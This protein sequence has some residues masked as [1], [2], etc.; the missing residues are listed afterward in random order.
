[1]EIIPRLIGY[2]TLLLFVTGESRAEWIKDQSLF[3]ELPK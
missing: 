2:R 3:C 1:M